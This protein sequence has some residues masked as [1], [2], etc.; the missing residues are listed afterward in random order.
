MIKK[1]KT[2]ESIQYQKLSPEEMKARGILGRLVGP[3][4][5]FINPTRN[6]RKYSEQLWENVFNNPLMQEK[7][8]NGVCYGELGHPEDRTETEIEKIAICLREQPVKNDKGQLV[9]VFDIL[10]TPCG[11]ILKTLCDYGSKLG[12]SSR[13]QGDL[14]TDYNGDESVDP[15]TYEC[16]CWDV[17]LVPGVETARLDY[18]TESL[19]TKNKKLKIALKE[20]LNEAEDKDKKIMEDTLKNLNIVVEEDSKEEDQIEV[21]EEESTSTEDLNDKLDFLAKDEEE[22][23]EGYE[24]VI[25]SIDDE[26]LIDQ[27]D[28]IKDEE[29]AHKKFLDAAKEDP[30]IDYED[31]EHEDKK[32]EINIDTV[33]EFL[34]SNKDET[35]IEKIKDLLLSKE[36][37]T[38]DEKSDKEPSLDNNETE[39]V[40]EV[41]ETEEPADD[42]GEDE[43]LEQL[44]EALKAKK[45][46]TERLQKA[47]NDLAVSDSKVTELSESCETYKKAIERLSRL[48][49]KNKTSQKQIDELTESLKESKETIEEQKKRI[50]RLVKTKKAALKETNELKEQLEKSSEDVKQLNSLNENLKLNSEQSNSTLKESFEKQVNDLTQKTKILTESLEKATKLKESYKEVATKAANKYIEVKAL[51]LGLTPRDIKRKLA[52]HYSLEQVDQV[53]EDLKSY[54]LNITRLP[55]SVNNKVGIRVNESNTAKNS[56]VRSNRNEDD[57]VDDSLIHL[58]NL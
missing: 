31:Y 51:M 47:Q 35:V 4:A 10:D 37:E 17:V 24:D 6:G 25:D 56:N 46:L 26:H 2:N 42:D 28:H 40:E 15:D 18:M 19:N 12:I 43:V 21:T 54:Q 57:D 9:A 45:D 29:E 48:A 52:E 7:I 32:E 49:Q 44:K 36:E 11:R 34:K 1:L 5:D 8:K 22:A 39:E 3:C 50:V 30:S 41:E 27:L 58:A 53:C 14:V 13:G 33:I 20:S 55:F 16:E 38:E 23:I